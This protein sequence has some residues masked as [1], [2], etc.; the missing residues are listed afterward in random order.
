MNVCSRDNEK[1]SPIH[2]YDERYSD[3]AH[4]AMIEELSHNFTDNTIILRPTY[5]II[6][7]IYYICFALPALFVLANSFDRLA[8]FKFKFHKAR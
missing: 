4:V 7:C 8:F 6:P 3:S 5:N 1:A 2:K